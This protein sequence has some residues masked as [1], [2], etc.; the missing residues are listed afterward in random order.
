MS[1]MVLMWSGRGWIIAVIT[2]ACL[3]ASDYL[4]SLRFSE[5]QY[6]ANHGWPKLTAFWLAALIVQWLVYHKKEELTL[7]QTLDQET[8]PYHPVLGNEDK[9]FLVPSQY[10]PMILFVVGILFYFLPSGANK[11]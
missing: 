1:G 11:P 7:E 4:T 9:L 8:E 2:F 6:Y 5:P 3:L 10:W